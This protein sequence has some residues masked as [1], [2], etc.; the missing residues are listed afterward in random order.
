[1]TKYTKE[2]AIGIVV[3]CAETYHKE[4]EG[5]NLLLLCQDKHKRIYSVQFS[6]YGNNFMH[7]TGLKPRRRD[8]EKTEQSVSAND[9]YQKCL[10]HKLSPSDFEFSDDGTTHMKLNVLPGIICKNLRAKSI[11][12]YNSSKPHLYTEKIVGRGNVK[13]CMGFVLDSA[14]QEYVP[15]TVIQEDIRDLTSKDVQ[16][17]AVYRK[18]AHEERYN[19][20]TYKAKNVDWEMV[21]YPE[22]L[23]YLLAL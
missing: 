15:N 7:L 2:Q 12:N 11:G 4:L 21:V 1:M 6:F 10:D 18:D 19:E 23:Q 13:A 3:R 16:V 22:E 17:I 5:K 9:F 14:R 8:G 20:V